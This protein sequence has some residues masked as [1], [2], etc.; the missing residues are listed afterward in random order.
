MKLLFIFIV[1]FILGHI[2]CKA[3]IK[4][5][6]LETQNLLLQSKLFSCEGKIL[7][8]SPSLKGKYYAIQH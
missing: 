1:F 3:L 6:D 8:Q 2:T 5:H 7:K 4:I